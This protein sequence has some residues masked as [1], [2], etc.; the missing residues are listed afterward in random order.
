LEEKRKSNP[1]YDRKTSVPQKQQKGSN[2]SQQDVSQIQP[3]D[4]EITANDSTND[5]VRR[6]LGKGLANRGILKKKVNENLK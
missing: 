1:D 3:F 6:K 4:I 5:N 2:K